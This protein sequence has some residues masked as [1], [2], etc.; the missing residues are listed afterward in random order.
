MKEERNR[1]PK[2]VAKVSY[3]QAQQEPLQLLKVA[4]FTPEE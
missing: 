4:F 3:T 2:A 1:E